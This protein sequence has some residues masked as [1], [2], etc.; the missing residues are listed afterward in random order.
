MAQILD[1]DPT[2]APTVDWLEIIAKAAALG[3]LS[4]TDAESV[5]DFDTQES[6]R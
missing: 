4:D 6:T 3:Q 5:T 1:R 2:D